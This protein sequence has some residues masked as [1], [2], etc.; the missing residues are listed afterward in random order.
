MF[1][2]NHVPVIVVGG[3]LGATLLV[4]VAFIV[5]IFRRGG[6]GAIFTSSKGTFL[7]FSV[8]V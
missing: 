7:Y 8:K 3:V 6:C 2:Q 4:A 1:S 5:I